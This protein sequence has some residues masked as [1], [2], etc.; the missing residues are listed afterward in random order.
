[1]VTPAGAVG[2]TVTTTMNISPATGAS[3]RY[4]ERYGVTLAVR[5]SVLGQ[6]TWMLE[7]SDVS[8]HGLFLPTDDPP[9]LRALVKLAIEL[10]TGRTLEVHGMA[11]HRVMPGDSKGRPPGVG[12][13]FYAVD[14]DTQAV[15]SEVV[16]GVSKAL[17]VSLPDDRR[18]Q[19]RYAAELDLEVRT[20]HDLHTLYTRDVS[21]GGMLVVTDLMLPVGESLCIHV[22]HPGSGV[23]F[24]LEA[25]VRRQVFH[26]LRGL[27]VE[28][29]GMD[30]QRRESFME[31]I[32]GVVTLP[33][34]PVYVPID[35]DVLAG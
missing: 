14:K 3:K 15:W 33:D 27:G 25:V 20:V 26:P 12:I 29:V 9:E 5:L 13:Q 22:I 30:P 1:M 19:P 28:F 6:K 18:G 34:D 7:T 8:Y 24:P 21:E 2:T 16:R 11:V 23:A 31:F 4:E 10:P 35:I 32:R 17:K